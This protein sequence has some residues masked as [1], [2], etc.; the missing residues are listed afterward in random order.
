MLSTVNPDVEMAIVRLERDGVLAPA[1]ARPLLR[2][3]RGEAVS[4]WTELRV[5]LYLGV[6]LIAAGAGLLIEQNLDRIG[7]LAIAVVLGAAA[8]ACLAWVVARSP[9]FSWG[10]VPSPH[11]ALDYL[12]LLGALL[13]ATDVAYIEAKFTPLGASWP[14]HLLLVGVFYAALA[15]RF[16]S[17]VLWALALTT[18]AAWRGVS[19][20]F[21]DRAPWDWWGDPAVRANAIACGLVF[22][23]AGALLKRR[24]RKPHFEPV[25]VDLGWFLVLAALA[26]GA[27][28]RSARSGWALFSW[29][30][31]AVAAAVAAVAFRS[32]RLVLLAMAAVGVYVA[33]SRLVVELLTG[34]RAVFAWFSGSA[35]AAVIGLL[36]LQRRMRERA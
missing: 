17:R 15:F 28:Q 36:A 13:T 16:D 14:L 33:V 12:L 7:P 29:L 2:R 34:E 9:R 20:R 21:L 10:E 31:L 24:G 30:L 8:V 18:L 26:S 11:L 35:I 19:V 22:A 32:G 23:V 25:A 6:T 27:L 4:L 1:V 5:L 3:A